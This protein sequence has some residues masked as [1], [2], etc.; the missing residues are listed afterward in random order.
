MPRVLRKAYLHTHACTRWARTWFG[1]FPVLFYA[2]CV[3]LFWTFCLILFRGRSGVRLLALRRWFFVLHFLNYP[4][5]PLCQ[6]ARDAPFYAC[7]CCCCLHLWLTGGMAFCMAERWWRAVGPSFVRTTAHRG[8]RFCLRRHTRQAFRDGAVARWIRSNARR[9]VVYRQTLATA[10]FV[11]LSDGLD[12]NAACAA[13]SATP[14]RVIFCV[15]AFC[16]YLYCHTACL[17][18]LLTP[19][20]YP[21]PP[22]PHLS[23]HAYPA[24]LPYLF[25]FIYST[26]L[27]G[28]PRKHYRPYGEAVNAGRALLVTASRYG[29]LLPSV[30]MG[31]PVR[32]AWFAVATTWLP[33]F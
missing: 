22:C 1:W 26:A 6:P 11:S 14:G 12:N 31:C 9:G 17:S 18:P 21:L 29:A 32:N 16:C 27:C 33:P 4:R 3:S 13:G 20:H 5:V 10:W 15:P 7:C 2:F 30:G 25:F 24:F 8:R 19:C 23:A 28:L